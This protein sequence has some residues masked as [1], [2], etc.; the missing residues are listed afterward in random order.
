MPM[1]LASAIVRV[2]VPPK[3]DRKPPEV[4]LPGRTRMRLE[5]MEAIWE[6]I[7][8]FAPDPIATMAITAATPMIIPSIVRAERSLLARRER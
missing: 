5:P 7:R 4:V 8:S 1:A 2:G 3:P 6:A